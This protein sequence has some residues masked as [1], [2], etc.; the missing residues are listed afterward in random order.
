M[1]VRG[2]RSMMRG[3]WAVRVRERSQRVCVRGAGGGRWGCRLRVHAWHA[4]RDVREV[5]GLS[6]RSTVCACA[7]TVPETATA[8]SGLCRRCRRLDV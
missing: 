3:R 2:A 1:C 7:C 8:G 6:A 4:Q 5:S